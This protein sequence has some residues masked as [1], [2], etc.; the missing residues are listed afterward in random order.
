[1]M[2]RVLYD[3]N[4]SEI[5]GLDEVE[6][7]LGA[8]E[9]GDVATL[10]RFPT[11]DELELVMRRSQV[12][13][14]EFGVQLNLSDDSGITVFNVGEN[15]SI[16][17][18]GGNPNA[19]KVFFHTHW[20][21]AERSNNSI[22]TL[23]P[24]IIPGRYFQMYA[25][26]L[27]QTA[28]NNRYGGY[29]NILSMEGITF[30]V[31][32]NQHS[33]SAKKVAEARNLVGAA[34]E[35]S[36]PVTFI[37]SEPDVPEVVSNYVTDETKTADHLQDKDHLVFSVRMPVQGLDYNFLFVTYRRL[38]Q[39]NIPIEQIAYKNGI[40]DL[41]LALDYK[42]NHT[43]NLYNAMHYVSGSAVI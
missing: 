32:V 6:A 11:Y 35:N 40:K 21:H 43:N 23:S 37:F 1:M 7:Q 29:T 25:G 27:G 19:Y 24:S 30:M 33:R 26:D 34:D 10:E 20:G 22:S 9:K 41:A 42:L 4:M 36:S 12:L 17:P 39:L 31:G 18:P 3:C 16:R 5:G 28:A 2:L 38:R 15:R 14:K 13:M 8:V